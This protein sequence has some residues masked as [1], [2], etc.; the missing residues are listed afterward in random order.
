MTPRRPL[1]SLLVLLVAPL[2]A[3]A[4]AAEVRE[5]LCSPIE[6]RLDEDRVEVTCLESAT[7]GDTGRDRE[8][9]VG[10]FA[11]PLLSQSFEPMLGS[12]V[13][14]VT[15]TLD[16]LQTALVHRRK[17][18]IWFDTDA[19]RLQQFGCDPAACRTLVA[20]ALTVEPA[21]APQASGSSTP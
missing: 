11:Y 1:L 16:M 10:R 13:H 17:L 5:I 19:S 6:V 7:L 9:E 12:Q 3:R 14:L 21:E 2:T 15:Y 18:R 4:A 20:V 8:S